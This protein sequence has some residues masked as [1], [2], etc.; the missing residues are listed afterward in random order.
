MKTDF[1]ANLSLTQKDRISVVWTHTGVWHKFGAAGREE[2]SWSCCMNEEKDSKGC[3]ASLKDSNRW[4]L[5][6]FNNN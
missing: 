4:N 2:W 5:A 1:K 6:S 3:S